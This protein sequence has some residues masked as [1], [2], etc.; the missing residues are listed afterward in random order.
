MTEIDV[1]ILK[2]IDETNKGDILCYIYSD[3]NLLDAVT[4]TED[5][6]EPAVT[7]LPSCP[8]QVIQI[9]A[10][11]LL[12]SQSI[13]TI[14]FRLGLLLESS[15]P[16]TLPMNSTLL[17]CIPN[18]ISTPTIQLK[19]YSKDLTMK[20]DEFFI[21]KYSENDIF[22]TMQN[23]LEIE[24]LKNI[25]LKQLREEINISESARVSAM[26]KLQS[27]V[28]EYEKEL[29]LLRKQIGFNPYDQLAVQQKQLEQ[30]F[31]KMVS[32]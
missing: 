14:Q 22:S 29:G 31:M 16:I 19:W 9:I 17:E 18:E 2:I 13:G 10:K 8:D 28:E 24:K 3:N 15:E 21:E 23:E 30:E 32:E 4:L 25:G 1:E 20:K 11:D 7:T 5:L 12:K 27:I 6:Y 26:Q